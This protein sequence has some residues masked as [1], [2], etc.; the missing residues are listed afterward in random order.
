LGGL[1]ADATNPVATATNRTVLVDLFAEHLQVSSNLTVIQGAVRLGDKTNQLSCDKLVVHSSTNNAA[2]QTAVAEGHVVVC[3]AGE[4]Q[5][6]RSDH[7][8]FSKTSGDAVFTGQPTWKLSPSE[9]RAERVTVRR[10][11]EVQALGEVAARVELPAQSTQLM[12]FFPTEPATNQTAAATNHAP[13]TIEVFAREMT[14]SE[15]LV[16]LRGDARVHQFPITGSEPHLRCET[17]DLFFATNTHRVEL[18]EAKHQ[19]RFEQGK[20]GVTNGPD[21]YRRFTAERLSAAW[22]SPTGGPSSFIAEQ[23]VVIDSPDNK[24]LANHATADKLTYT[25]KIE[26][27]TTNQTMELTGHPQLTNTLGRLVGDLIIWDLANDRISTR[28]YNVN[29]NPGALNLGTN[30]LPTDFTKPAKGKKTK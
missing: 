12:N 15:Q 26:N 13:L 30:Q 22:T 24:G 16:S 23:Q 10:S 2:E 21:V 20:A 4:D 1:L 7:A 29:L 18:M 11:R 27:G 28:N 3:L 19:V 17:L 9:G 25:H 6:L 14:A 5:C 8:V